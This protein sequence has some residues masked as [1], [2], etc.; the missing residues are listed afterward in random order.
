MESVVATILKN[1]ARFDRNW[2]VYIYVSKCICICKYIYICIF[3]VLSKS[4]RMYVYIH[5]NSIVCMIHD[6][7][8]LSNNVLA[9]W[10]MKRC[11]SKLDNLSS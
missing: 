9:A 4:V 10:R 8:L 3:T 2:C 11:E 6:F 1:A 7:T 5:E